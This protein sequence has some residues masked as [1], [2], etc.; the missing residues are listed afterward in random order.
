[1]DVIPNRGW[2]IV[3]GKDSLQVFVV[4]SGA[5]VSEVKGQLEQALQQQGVSVAAIQVASVESLPQAAS[6]KSPLI[7]AYKG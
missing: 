4:H 7:E 2:R 5:A 3:Q 6:G 1:M